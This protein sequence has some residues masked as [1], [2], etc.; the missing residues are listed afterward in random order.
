MSTNL[1]SLY[2]EAVE[3]SNA[4]QAFED[5]VEFDETSLFVENITK[6]QTN[7]V[8]HI[9]EAAEKAVIEAAA[10]G[11]KNTVVFN[12]RG[13]DVFEGFSILFMLLGGVEYDQKVR[14][15]NYG[16]EPAMDKLNNAVRPFDLRHTW[17]R[18]TN[19]NSIVLIWE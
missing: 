10:S 5:L 15:G 16:F 14:L 3:V 12:F 4:A 11:A 1:F 17:D 6:A 8:D 18:S 9:L 7:L 19:L 2:A 13:A